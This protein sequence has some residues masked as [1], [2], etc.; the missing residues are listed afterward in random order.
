[1]QAA[2]CPAAIGRRSR[3]TS[4]HVPA[5][6]CCCRV[7]LPAVR[8]A[9]GRSQHAQDRTAAA[10]R[11]RPGARA[12]EVR[13]EV[14]AAALR[15]EREALLLQLDAHRD[16]LRTHR[17]RLEIDQARSSRARR[18][19][20]R[21]LRL[22]VG[23]DH[24]IPP[25]VAAVVERRQLDGA[26]IS[27]FTSVMT[28][29]VNVARYAYL[30]PGAFLIRPT[31]VSGRAQHATVPCCAVRER[32][33]TVQGGADCLHASSAGA[34]RRAGRRGAGR[35]GGGARAGCAAAA[36][37]ARAAAARAPGRAPAAVHPGARPAAGMLARRTASERVAVRP[38][39]CAAGA[40]GGRARQTRRNSGPRS[41]GRP[42]W[43]V[44][45]TV[46]CEGPSGCPQAS[47]QL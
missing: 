33:R 22:S 44:R 11:G 24:G 40:R 32:P 30:Y 45:R 23:G 17:A 18:P 9:S 46:K 6:C 35:R 28:C 29:S 38:G 1:M 26:T 34:A 12:Q 7:P 36:A 21:V 15:R 3:D 16:R 39:V 47:R 43:S 25:A 27:P 42:C 19:S 41:V 31:R 14:A 37:P 10:E 13:A 5:R 2:A 8:C 4:A 20:S